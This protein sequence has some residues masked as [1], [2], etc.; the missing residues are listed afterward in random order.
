MHQVAQDS[1][2]AHRRAQEISEHAS[3]R[4]RGGDLLRARVLYAEAAQLEQKAL[5]MIPPG[6]SRTR[7]I[8]GVSAVA[9]WCKS[10]RYVQA[11]KLAQ[12]LLADADLPAFARDQ[13][14]ELLIDR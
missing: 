11:D 14:K 12:E 5:S 10:A 4:R 1:S 8:L 7:A 9:L 13:I 3:L 2:A 6:H